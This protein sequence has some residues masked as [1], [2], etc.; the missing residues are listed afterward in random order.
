V[1]VGRSLEGRPL[2]AARFGAGATAALVFGAIHG[3]EPE[4]AELCR[5]FAARLG[6]APAPPSVMVVP[7]VNP[8]GLAAGTKDNA[9]GVDL[10]R[11]FP[12]RNFTRAHPAGYDPGA[13]PLSEPESAALATLVEALA[14]RVLVAVH[15]P[16]RCVNWDGPAEP[17]A[18]AMSDACGYPARASVGYPTPGSFG[19]CYGVDRGLIVITL[20]LPRLVADEDYAACLAAL[21][22]ATLFGPA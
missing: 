13:S 3:D 21:D 12:A 14:P 2:Q 19:S 16:F 6:A 4:S 20:E 7:V 22:C 9:R 10:N 11:N 8:D 18:R 15:Q 5:R 1:I 17:L